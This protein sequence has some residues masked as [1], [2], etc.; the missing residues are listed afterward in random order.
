MSLM[1][2]SAEGMPPHNNA[3]ER[4]LQRGVIRRKTNFG[5]DSATDT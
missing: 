3:A 1:R 2:A 5:T 4:A